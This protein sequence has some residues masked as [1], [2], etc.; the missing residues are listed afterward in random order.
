MS[1]TARL[2][3]LKNQRTPTRKKDREDKTFIEKM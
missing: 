3:H 2:I 1:P